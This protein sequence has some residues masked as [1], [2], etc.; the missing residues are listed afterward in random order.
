MKKVLFTSILLLSAV[1]FGG[2]IYA[3]GAAGGNDTEVTPLSA[4]QPSVKFTADGNTLTISGQ[5]DLTSYT[6]T[7]WTA[8]VFTDNAV[9]FVFTDADGKTPV[10]AGD[11]YNAGKTYYHATYNYIEV[12]KE[13]PVAW[14]PYFGTVT[15]E[16]SWKDNKKANLYMATIDAYN[17]NVTVG[18]KVS[19]NVNWDQEIFGGDWN[20][21]EI[22]GKKYVKVVEVTGE[23]PT[24]SVSFD[25]LQASGI[26][27][28]EVSELQSDFINTKVT[29]QIKD[30][31]SLFLSSDGGKTYKGLTSGV[32][33]EWTSDDVFYQGTA[34]YAAIKDNNA[35]FDKHTDYVQ[36]DNTEISFKELLRR[37]ILEGVSVYDYNAK[38]EVGVSSYT[39]VKFVNNGSDPLL[40]DAD[41][42][43]GILYP[44]SNGML[45][46]NVTTT[47]LDLGEATLNELN[48]DIF[49]PSQDESYKCLKLAL[50]DITFPKTKLTSVY[51]ESTKQDENKM[52]LPA[53]LLS[54]ITRYIKTVSIPEGYDRIADGAF[55]NENKQ[56]VLENVNLPQGLTLI[57]KNAFQNCNYIKSIE[58]NEGLE[59]IG[60]SA[61]FGTTLGTVK[62]PS[63]L[64][65]INDCAFAN[66]HIYNLKFN[67]G[68]K[69][70]GNSA[71]AL[72]NEHTEEVLEIPASVIYIGPYA[73]NF[74]QY[75]DVY[76]YGEKAPLMP[77]GSYKLDAST[78]DL[79]TAFPQ[80][81]LNGNNGFDPLPKEGEK[82]TG[83]D[84]SSGYAN[85]E[86]YK[87]QGVYLCMLHYPKELSD[88]NRDTYTDITRVY[89]TY[90]TAD[91][92]FIATDTGTDDA[93]DKV[94]KEEKD[95]I[96]NAGL[97]H[98]FKKVTWGYADTYLGEQYI[99]PSHSQFNRAY[100][101]ASHSV[102]WD[103]VTPVTCDLSAEEIAA[104]KYAGYDTS[105]ENL[106]E[107]KKIAHMGTRQFVLAN[108]D[109]N[110][111]KEPEKEPEYPVDVKGGKWWTLCLPF[112]MTKAMV[113]ET[114]GKD[115]Q[116]C[117]FD[118]V[119][120]QVNE[121]TR[122]NR[123][124]LYF[125]QNVYKHKTEPKNADG[126]WNF[127]PTA[128]AP[129][130]K[131]IVIYAHESYMIY[132]TKTGE[133]AVFA[134]KNYQPAVGSPTPTVVMGKNEYIGAS[135][136]PDNVP[137]RYVGNY[138]E[139]VDAQTAS[140]SVDAQALQE[141]KIPKYSYVYASDGKVTKF[142]FLTKDNMTWK[143]NKCVVQTNNRGDG[144]RDHEEFFDYNATGAKQASF[145]GEDFIDTPTSIEDEMV[146]IAGEG[147]DA[148]VYSLD[149][150]LVNS[151]G[152]LTGLPKGVYI[153]GGKKY[154]VK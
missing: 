90:R 126:T 18:N 130:D 95:E 137:Y 12:W 71:F 111:D 4:T 53:Q 91:G 20:Y 17:K 99:W 60:D 10:A 5:G 55:S 79:G 108:A 31:L 132:P 65:I 120:R 19:D 110:E 59:N 139:S 9:G 149:G 45:T 127:Q 70:I 101:T 56:S 98:S 43:R 1:S 49:I 76:F 30:K 28:I 13:Q 124:V 39:T 16:R 107:L 87:N 2:N 133:D 100:C 32:D 128:Q 6:T 119:V 42:V 140:Q 142:W 146:I 125:T 122:K 64:K 118:R 148:P 129:A 68:L 141:V 113:D 147:S 14:N 36:A 7:D 26:K 62:F 61:F 23:V 24:S 92:K 47:E 84:T 81:T 78:K 33:Y 11:S 85:R 72:S 105:K 89:K 58:L 94:G 73:F 40:I 22:D 46:T 25:N 131:D 117:L 97:C 152:D 80:Q 37:K 151:T 66:C 77:L 8:K 134:V 150:T 52:V 104:L 83:D 154:V 153:K 109:V 143:P 51:S 75:Q 69:Y 135:S 138:L 3:Q 44:T 21:T 144:K 74:R 82:I 136:A 63:S 41:V 86:N 121:T 114:F 38:K 102:K 96:L 116:V 29:Y 54:N 103:G 34:T 112:N 35:F 115:T 67:A 145:F 15:A 57:G 106:D 27:L 93:T 50:N 123:I 88:E 48:A